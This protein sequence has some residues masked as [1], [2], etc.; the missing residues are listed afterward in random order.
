M[1]LVTTSGH[2]HLR[3]INVNAA[4][5]IEG[6]GKCTQ[7]RLAEREGSIPLSSTRKKV[8]FGCSVF[9]KIKLL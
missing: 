4:D 8:L 1:D 3:I 5:I 6:E 9:I 7:G 2:P